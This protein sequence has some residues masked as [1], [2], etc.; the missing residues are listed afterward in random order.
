MVKRQKEKQ[1]Q[2]AHENRQNSLA[3]SG[4]GS[5]NT[6]GGVVQ[7]RLPF[8]C[9]ALTQVPFQHPVCMKNGIIIESSA[10]IDFIVQH[11]KDPITGEP[12]LSTKDEKIITLHMDKD[13]EGRWQC[14]ILTKPFSDYTKIVAIWDRKNNEAYVYS[15]EAYKEL[16]INP[17]NYIDL[18][19]GNKF[20]PQKDVL[21]LND[22]QD[23]TFQTKRE[24]QNFWYIQNGRTMQM[25]KHT[26][27]TTTNNTDV[28]H[29]VTATRIM[30]QIQKER[31]ENKRKVTSNE[32]SS[33]IP[34]TTIDSNNNDKKKR[35]IILA[36]DVTGVKYTSGKAAG[37]LT[38][39][40]M[41]IVGDGKNGMDGNNNNN[42]L[43][44]ATQEEI[45]QAQFKVMRHRKEKGY[46]RMM[47]NYGDLLLEL[48]CE[49]TPRTCTNFLGL[50]EQKVY[51]GTNFHRLIPG[52]MIQ[53]GK[54]NKEGSEDGSLWGPAFQDEFDDRLKH[55]GSGRLSMANAGPG[56]NKQQFFIT[57][58]PCPHLDR[59]HTIFGEVVD[60]DSILEKIQRVKTD[61][62][63]R[64][65]EAV[66][67]KKMEILVDP[68]KEAAALEEVRIDRLVEA[69]RV[70]TEQKKAKSLGKKITVPSTAMTTTMGSTSFGNSSTTRST[71]VAIG[72][73]LPASI[74][75]STRT[76][77]TTKNT[78][79][80]QQDTES[81]GFPI[82]PI[83]VP[84]KTK[85]VVPKVTKFGNFSGW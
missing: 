77:T 17:K 79:E 84:T 44:E 50:C 25:N 4:M 74:I 64:P 46:V 32:E 14:P 33:S 47:T 35:K 16:N 12:L 52:F 54:A 40:S 26:T 60:G 76:T 78:D 56:T 67:I 48:H 41:E 39:S 6:N 34:T 29:S 45:L 20:H 80:T 61:K 19:T 59:K 65:L 70:E 10:L 27:T 68:A 51:D 69:R 85:T 11:K 18:I 63:D 15:Y 3:R 24:I 75:M 42:N 9:C 58:K 57:F 2:S 73:Y 8:F 81:D 31:I 43:R 22:P 66:T 37:S 23:D 13:E 21:I 36:E 71:A 62:K 5:S 7:K 83:P 38:S 30:E 53:G 82:L 49:M 55:I 28:K 1:Y 72:K